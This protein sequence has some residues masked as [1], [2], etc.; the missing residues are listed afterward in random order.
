MQYNQPYGMPPEVTYG[1]TPYINGNPATGT[2][3]SIPPAASIE[4]PQRE[5][6]N[7][8]RDAALLT[9]SNADLHQLAKS[10]QSTLL[11]SDD[12]QGTANQYQV[13]QAPAPTAYFKYMTVVMK[14]ANSNTAAATLNVN[15]LGAKPIKK[16]DGTDCVAG[17]IIANAIMCFIYDGTNFQ[18]VWSQVGIG[19]S[20]RILTAPRTYYVNPVTGNDAWDGTTAAQVAGT[21]HGPFQHIMK[22]VN[23]AFQFQPSASYP[24]TIQLA[25]GTYLETVSIPTI[26]GPNLIINGN[27][28]I[29]TNVFINSTGLGNTISVSGPNNVTVQNL[30]VKCQT[31]NFAALASNGAGATLNTSNTISD[32]VTTWVFLANGLGAVNM[33]KHT[34][35]ASFGYGLAA[36]RNG[37]LNMNGGSLTHIFAG[38]LTCTTFAQCVS[39]GQIEVP[40]TGTPSFS[41]APASGSKYFATLNG[42]INTQGQGANYFPGP[43]AG[44]LTQGGQYA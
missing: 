22:A 33:G 1:D 2:Q 38:S 41:G 40:A 23:T 20:Q 16:L 31:V 8:I 21:I 25:D 18:I 14:V 44:S 17:D 39:G 42:V 36:Y 12:D 26:P 28:T 5:I 15:A 43:T 24:I 27:A 6:V 3:G 9:P 35:N 32:L 30:M 10:I 13:T 19:N 29:P 11:Y 7:L 34:F 37:A 4:Y